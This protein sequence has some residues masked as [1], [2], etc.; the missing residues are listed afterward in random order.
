MAQKG[1]LMKVGVVGL[2]YVGLVTA[3]VLANAGNTVIGVD[4]DNE[5]IANLKN[6]IVN[7][8]EPGLE[9]A[10]NQAYDKINFSIDYA[11]LKDTNLIYIIVSTPTKEG[12]ILLDYVFDAIGSIKNSNDTATIVIKSTVV[13]GT[14]RRVHERTGLEVV[15]NPEFIKEGNAIYDTI[16]PD[17]IIIGASNKKSLDLVEN[18]WSFTKAPIVRTTNENAELIKYASNSF[19]ATKISFINE[20][21]NLCEKIPNADIE[22]VAKGMGLD[23]RIGPYFLKAGIGYGGSCFLKDTRAFTNFARGLE[24]KLNIVEA[25]MKVNN[26]RINRIIN[27]V[28]V[29]VDDKNIV[30]GVLGIAFKNN[31][32]DMRESQALKLIK[33]MQE[34]NFR[35][36]AYDPVIK[37]VKGIEMVHSKEECIKTS[38]I[39][40]IATEWEE[41]KDIKTKK[42]IIDAR[43]MLDMSKDNI[44]AIGVS[45]Y[46]KKEE[47]L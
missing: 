14:A 22:V 15:S 17:R 12:K 31:T 27:L 13:P 9:G 34:E 28:K 43:R 7:I 41:F 16:H 29:E 26:D 20:I 21:A 39:L 6:R 45:G 47:I 46:N 10:F 3:I 36:K 2:G 38:N 5:K 44:I 24:E 42:L 30:V 19:L 23:K 35:V 11:S 25:A 33:R 1:A 8:Y 37:E 40:I 4:I 32:N 18:L